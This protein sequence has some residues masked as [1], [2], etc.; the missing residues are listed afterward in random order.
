MAD[1]DNKLDFLTKIDDV[2]WNVGA[3]VQFDGNGAVVGGNAASYF[4]VSCHLWFNISDLGSLSG[5]NETLYVFG[6]RPFSD[7]D[8]NTLTIFEFGGQVE[9]ILNASTDFNAATAT[10]D[11]TGIHGPPAPITGT[12]FFQGESNLMPTNQLS[13]WNHLLISLDLQNRIDYTA[14]INA[15]DTGTASKPTF[16]FFLNG[17]DVTGIFG[18]GPIYYIR[19]NGDGA[20]FQE[21]DNVTP[22]AAVFVFNHIDTWAANGLGTF[23]IPTNS[24]VNFPASGK[25]AVAE[26]RMWFGKAITD[27]SS[28]VTTSKGFVTPAK[29]AQINAAYG[30]PDIYRHGDEKQF[31]VPGGSPIGTGVKT[32]PHNPKR[33]V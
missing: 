23:G 6:P 16:H 28:L 21:L 20:V 14:M 31:I 9:F 29:A 1:T 26:F 18:L 8:A 2:H 22:N 25:I 11:V 10:I 7:T 19:E 4:Q 5:V 24:A 27:P 17:V 33:A 32:Y 3:S 15:I 12:A 30:V 13:G